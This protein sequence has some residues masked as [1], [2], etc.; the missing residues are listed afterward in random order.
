MGLDKDG[1]GS[2]VGCDGELLGK[3]GEEDRDA[4]VAAASCEDGK[5]G[6]EGERGDGGREGRHS[7]AEGL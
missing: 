2:G 3:L 5:E 4:M 1:I 7:G 6:V